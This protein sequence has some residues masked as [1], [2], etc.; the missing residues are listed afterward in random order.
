MKTLTVHVAKE[1]MS[2][3][4]GEAH[5]GDLVVLTDGERR[6]E[7]EATPPGGG[8]LDLDLEEDSPE[9]E[10]ELVKAVKGP[11]APFSEAELRGLADRALA[12]H[13]RRGAA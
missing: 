12:E 6:M 2:Q 4:L 10:A 13:R 5:R 9:L 1:Q 11:H 8:A 3:L 7:L